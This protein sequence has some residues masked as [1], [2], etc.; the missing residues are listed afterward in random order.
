[1]LNLPK[2]RIVDVLTI[3]GRAANLFKRPLQSGVLLRFEMTVAEL[4]DG[5]TD[6]GAKDHRAGEKRRQEQG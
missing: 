2:H 4:R 3:A 1:M 5:K 6:R